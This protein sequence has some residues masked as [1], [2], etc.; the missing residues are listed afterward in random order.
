MS[1]KMIAYIAVTAHYIDNDWNLVSGVISFAEL[2]GSHT[3]E[4]LAD[5]LVGIIDEMIE[6]GHV[7]TALIKT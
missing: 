5:H 4:H 3:G 1:A 6:P 7:S 2:G